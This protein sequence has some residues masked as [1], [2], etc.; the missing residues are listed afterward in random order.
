M[1]TA[2]TLAAAT[3]SR[4]Q[5]S[6]KDQASIKAYYQKMDKATVRGD[7][8]TI[9]ACTA[10]DFVAIDSDGQKHTKSEVLQSLQNVMKLGKIVSSTTK[11]LSMKA[12]GSHVYVDVVSGGNIAVTVKGQRHTLREEDTSTDE[13][14][15]S[16]N[17]WIE[18]RS[19]EHS[20]KQ[21]AD[22]KLYNQSPQPK[23]K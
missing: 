10:P 20:T 2:L 6:A 1:L 3:L 17:S 5:L 15:R 8:K 9:S 7:L 23:G 21:Y 4:Q 12:K 11:I 18:T 14:S 13:L 22:G 16:G 19:E